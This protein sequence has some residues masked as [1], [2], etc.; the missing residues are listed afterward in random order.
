MDLKVTKVVVP[1]EAGT[2]IGWVPAFAGM[3]RLSTGLSW[4][5]GS[6]EGMKVAVIL[7]IDSRGGRP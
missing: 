6:P 1:A 2:N 4:A 7:S 5:F 3:T